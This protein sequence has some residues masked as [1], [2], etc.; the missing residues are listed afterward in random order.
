MKQRKTLFIAEFFSLWRDPVHARTPATSR[1]PKEHREHCIGTLVP[2][3][4]LA[5]RDSAVAAAAIAFA[6]TLAIN[7][8]RKERDGRTGR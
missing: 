6:A 5:A 8:W 7:L 3:V 2:A 4:A 1:N